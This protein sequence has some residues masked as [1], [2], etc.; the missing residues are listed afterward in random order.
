M[1]DPDS[2]ITLLCD[3]IDTIFGPK[4]REHE[5]VRGLLNA[6]HRKGAVAGRCIVRGKTVE[7]V[8]FPAYAAVALAGLGA[9]PATILSR[10]IVIHMRRRASHE[11]VEPF[12]RRIEEPTGHTLRD[13]LAVVGGLR[14]GD[15]HRD[16][17]PDAGRGGG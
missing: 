12:R 1:G 16:V 10:S 8:E 15:H 11:A 4:A 5:D 6:G 2:P 14:G 17:A 7:T 9:L 13:E 3:E